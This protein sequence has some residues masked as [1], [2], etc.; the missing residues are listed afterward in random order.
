M[1]ASSSMSSILQ[2]SG[3]MS[4]TELPNLPGVKKDLAAINPKLYAQFKASTVS[5]DDESIVASVEA[6]L[7]ANETSASLEDFFENPSKFEILNNSIN[8][9]PDEGVAYNDVYGG[10]YSIHSQ[11]KDILNK[12][13]SLP[14]C[15]LDTAPSFVRNNDTD[16]R[17][18]GYSKKL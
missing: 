16:L 18:L 9:Y 10:R 5:I 17:F 2:K 14:Y 4:M 7:R 3:S 15:S 6:K 11:K 8:Q 13:R 1:R 12:S